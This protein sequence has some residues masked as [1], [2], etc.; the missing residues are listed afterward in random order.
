MKN[1]LH[2]GLFILLSGCAGSPCDPATGE[3]VE[4]RGHDIL[5]ACAGEISTALET[6]GTNDGLN[7]WNPSH[8]LRASDYL[9]YGFDG[10]GLQFRYTFESDGSCREDQETFTS[11][12][13]PSWMPGDPSGFGVCCDTSPPSYTPC[14]P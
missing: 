5:A 3:C 14:V 6:Y 12:T 2:I 8:A 7:G 11:S 10:D 13:C 1:A 9:L 4:T